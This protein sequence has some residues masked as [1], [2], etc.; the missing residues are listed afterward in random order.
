MGSMVRQRG[1][2]RLRG[3]VSRL[4]D[5][6][7]GLLALAVSLLITFAIYG[8]ALG[9]SF[10]LDDA[11]DLTRTQ[12]HSYWELLTGP[13]PGYVYYRPAP[14]L[15]WKFSY[16]LLGYYSMALLHLLPLAAHAISGWL[17]Y[18]L[19][20][21]MTGSRWSLLPMILFL[22]YPFSYQA[23]LILGTLVHTLVTVLLLAVAVL[24]IDG[25]RLQSRPRLLL[26]V[27]L[28]LAALWAHEYGVLVVPLL[29]LLEGW[30]VLSRRARRPAIAWLTPVVLGEL[31]YLYLWFNLP[32]PNPDYVSTTQRLQSFR[33]WLQ[34]FAY[35]VS[36]QAVW[37]ADLLSLNLP[38]L[39]VF[40]SVLA[41]GLALV[42][43]WRSGRL[44]TALIL[45]GV[46]A[47]AFAPSAWRLTYEYV[48][49]GP[50]LLY[51][52]AIGCAFFWGVLPLISNRLPR[53]RR[54]VK[55]VGLAF[56]GLVIAQSLLFIER[57]TVMLEQGTLLV[58][59]VIEA[60]VRHEREGLLVLNLPAWFAPKGQEFPFGHL[61][62]QLE[63]DYIGLDRVV[64]AGS[65]RRVEVE[66]RSL[67][68]GVSGWRY[69]FQPH[70]PPIDHHE[71]DAF[72]RAGRALILADLREDGPLVREPGRLVPGQPTPEATLAT[73]A[74]ALQ[75]S[76]Q[77]LDWAGRRLTITSTWHLT[78]ALT[79]DVQIWT[80]ARDRDG[81]V[82]VE[83]RDYALG[84]MAA[85]RLWQPGDAV[86]DRLL[87]DL[88]R[89]VDPE[90][91]EVWVALVNTADEALLPV[92]AGADVADGWVRVGPIE[93]V[94][95]AP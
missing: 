89:D 9:F 61:G 60:G 6:S 12:E 72:L 57:R 30:F 91:V 90:Q 45:I 65:G 69:H 95:A 81:A 74:D 41:V 92:V 33:L 19:G 84:G 87:L 64:Y 39:V 23:L 55:A 49:N 73:F 78:Q 48:Q 22:T 35:P 36:R 51:P 67:A 20:R 37:I 15:I 8:R 25:R 32:K 46:S 63:P 62:V 88:P 14:F 70:G 83:Q 76:N 54:G 31:L 44:L 4:S 40:L 27:V 71:V 1:R 59:G 47:I 94:T 58:N 21:R 10:F 66:S 38:L 7:W 93:S 50:R 43:Y 3:A 85:P 13:L 80:Q 18:L 77:Q 86:E 42:A 75:L 29:A 11:F 5:R 56:V 52:A 53:F 17:I 2:E 16:D 26:A 82:L 68:P 79:T 34:D 28:S 24:W